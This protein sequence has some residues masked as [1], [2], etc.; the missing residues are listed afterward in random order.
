VFVCAWKRGRDPDEDAD[1]REP[2]QRDVPSS[3]QKQNKQGKKNGSGRK[4]EKSATKDSSQNSRDGQNRRGKDRASGASGGGSV[5]TPSGVPTRDS[6][7]Q[8]AD[9]DRDR[10]TTRERSGD[11]FGSDCSP[12][13][14]GGGGGGFVASFGSTPQSC[15]GTR[16]RRIPDVCTALTT[17]EDSNDACEMEEAF[18]PNWPVGNPTRFVRFRFVCAGPV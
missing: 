11:F 3:P 10:Q 5:K 6:R 9:R 15:E 13:G 7:R 2:Q 4:G 17:P 16:K 18:R 14:G 8:S 12:F 1:D